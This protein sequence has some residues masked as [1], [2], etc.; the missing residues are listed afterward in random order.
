M[1]QYGEATLVRPVVQYFCDEEDRDVLLPCRLWCEKV[2]DLGNPNVS[3]ADTGMVIEVEINEPW[4][5]TRPDSTALGIFSFQYCVAGY[6]V[7]NSS[8]FGKPGELG[9][10]YLDCILYDWFAVLDNEA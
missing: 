9:C 8:Y 6:I 1:F 2:V 5:A 4:S 10:T 7:G 3:C